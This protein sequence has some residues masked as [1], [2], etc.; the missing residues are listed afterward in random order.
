MKLPLRDSFEYTKRIVK[1]GMSVED[2]MRELIDHCKETSTN[3]LWDLIEEI[4]FGES[5]PEAEKWLVKILSNQPPESEVNSFW[6]GL[7][8][9]VLPDKKTGCDFYISGSDCFDPNDKYGDW[10]CDPIYFPKGRYARSKVLHEIYRIISLDKEIKLF[11]E[12]VLCLGYT[13]LLLTNIFKNLDPELLIGESNERH[14]AVG[15][16]SGD[17]IL[18]GKVDAS[19]FEIYMS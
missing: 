15:F 10:A 1:S 13:G 12:Y 9:P 14:I 16:D 7:F 6:F 17:F 19:G 4:D 2:G 5:V 3:D 11:G 18:L 8:N